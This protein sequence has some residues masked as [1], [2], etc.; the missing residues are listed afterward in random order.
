MGSLITLLMA[1]AAAAAAPVPA[2]NTAPRGGVQVIAVARA[3]ILRAEHSLSEAGESGMQRKKRT[4]ADG[5]VQ[6]EFY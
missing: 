5:S 4:R 6:I 1:G 3:E 2:E